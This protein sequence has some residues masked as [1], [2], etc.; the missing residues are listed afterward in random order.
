M[1]RLFTL[2]VSLILSISL[3]SQATAQTKDDGTLRILAIGNS[4]SDDG[5]EYLPALLENL[6]VENVEVARL[7]VG[8]CTLEQHVNFYDNSEAA[9]KFY[10]SK[11]GENKWVE[12]PEKVTM[13]YALAMGEWDIITMQQASGFSGMYDSYTPYLGRL[14]EAVKKAQPQAELVWHMTWSYSSDSNHKHYKHYN[15]DQQQMNS[16]INNCLHTLLAEFDEIERIVPSGTA[17]KSLRKSAINNYPKDLTRDGFHMGHGAGRYALACTWYETL[18]EP[19]TGKSMMG[20]TLRVCGGLVSVSDIVALYCQ[21]AAKMAAKHPF[22]VSN[23]KVS[24][25]KAAKA[26]GNAEQTIIKK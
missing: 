5:T 23:I 1:K 12:N 3:I 11:A 18:V 2:T 7:Y 25:A 13:Q 10:H 26:E 16:A 14:I 15:N 22:K 9:Y 19:Y 20:N 17:V 6:N 21:K 8:G 24:A 4:F